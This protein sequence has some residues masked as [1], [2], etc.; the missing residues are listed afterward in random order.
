M[1]TLPFNG[2]KFV[3]KINKSKWWI[4]QK[5]EAF[6]SWKRKTIHNSMVLTFRVADRIRS[7][8]LN[9]VFSLDRSNT[10][11]NW[12]VGFIFNLNW[13]WTRMFV[14]SIFPFLIWLQPRMDVAYWIRQ[15][16]NAYVIL[17][18]DMK[19]SCQAMTGSRYSIR[20]HLHTLLTNELETLYRFI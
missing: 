7:G 3:Y 11:F 13:S 5:K 18:M 20:L 17:W 10:I 16:P 2:Y 15:L 4:E 8:F 9:S 12:S 6:L 19:Y 14:F 1:L